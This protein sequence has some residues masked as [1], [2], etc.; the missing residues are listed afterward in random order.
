MTLLIPAGFVQYALRVKHDNDPELM[1]MTCGHDVQGAT[2]TPA[3]DL[4]AIAGAWQNLLTNLCTRAVFQDIVGY[5]G[6]SDPNERI[7]VEV[8]RGGR[9]AQ[10][11]QMLPQNV[12]MLVKKTTNQGG[13][14]G[15]GRMFFPHLLAESTVDETG[16]IGQST[17]TAYQDLLNTVRTQ[18]AAIGGGPVLLHATSLTSVAGPP[19]PVNAF[20]L[21]SVVATQRR[22]LRR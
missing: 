8:A 1:I 5:Y 3:G 19:T 20:V 11:D 7:V 22:R 14:R 16:N 17:V 6:T 18:L 2:G 4:D 12:A 10:P 21:S 9:G 15:R 13:R